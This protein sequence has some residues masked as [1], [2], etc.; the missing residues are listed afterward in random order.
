MSLHQSGLE[1]NPTASVEAETDEWGR[2]KV[3][4]SM[5]DVLTDHK[6]PVVVVGIRCSLR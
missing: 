3:L 6:F 2:Q 5:K 1:C 4:P